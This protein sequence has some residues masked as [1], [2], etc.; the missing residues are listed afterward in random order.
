MHD[1]NW[2]TEDHEKAFD[3]F[4]SVSETLDLE[5]IDSDTYMEVFFVVAL[6]HHLHF[7]DRESLIR[8]IEGGLEAVEAPPTNIEQLH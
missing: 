1:F 8:L 5:G 3:C 6:T 4:E 2:P 7:S